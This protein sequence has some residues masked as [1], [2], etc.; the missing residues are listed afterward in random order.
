MALANRWQAAQDLSAV[1]RKFADVFESGGLGGG[2]VELLGEAVEVGAGELPLKRL[3]D[4]LV[5]A[6]ERE[7]L[8]FEVGESREVVGGEDLA[9]DDGEVNLG[10]VEPTGVDGGV[11]EEQV[12]VPV[13]KAFDRFLAAVR[14]AVVDDH[15]HAPGLAVGLDA[16]ELLDQRV[17]RDD[18]VDGG[19]PIE[20]LRAAC[21]PGR[22]VAQSPASLV[23]VLDAL[24][25]LDAGLGGQ[26]CVLAGSGLDRGFLVAAHDVIA[27]LQ[28]FAFPSAGVE[29]EVPAGLLGEVGVAR[30]DPG[31]VLPRLDRILLEP[32]PDRDPGDLLADPASDS[33]TR[34]LLR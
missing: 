20:Q 3:G 13:S 11:H 28:Q 26:R 4:L 12:L 34:E 19:A 30:E 10:L 25:T 15:E 17:E 24:T 9:L 1:A 14:G 18:P 32:A 8:L 21:V 22:Q 23:F 33:F 5:A 16:H 2:P 29:V 7:E 27:G 31:A 6:A